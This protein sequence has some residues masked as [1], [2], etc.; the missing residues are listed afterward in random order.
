MHKLELLRGSSSLHRLI[1]ASRTELYDDMADPATCSSVPP[2]PAQSWFTAE[3]KS[4]FS[5]L[6][7][8]SGQCVSV[9]NYAD[10]A[11]ARNA[12]RSIVGTPTLSETDAQAIRTAFVSLSGAN[13]ATIRTEVFESSD[14]PNYALGAITGN[15]LDFFS[16]G[17]V[18]A[19]EGFELLE[20]A[21]EGVKLCLPYEATDSEVAQCTAQLSSARG[22]LSCVRGGSVSACTD[23][24]NAGQATLTAMNGGDLYQANRDHGFTPIVAERSSDG[25]AN[26]IG[27]SYY[28]TAI[29]PADSDL[30]GAGGFSALEGRNACSTGYRKTAGEFP[31]SGRRRCTTVMSPWWVGCVV[32]PGE[33]TQQPR[34]CPMRCGTDRAS[35]EWAP[36]NESFDRQ[37]CQ[38]TRRL[39]HADRVHGRQRHH[40]CGEPRQEGQRRRRVVCVFLRRR[41]RP[42]RD[43][44]GP[45]LRERG[46][47]GRD[48]ELRPPL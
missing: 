44:R 33:C 4:D 10:C 26:Q 23:M 1:L 9:E 40:A 17:A 19:Y 15:F 2:P 21:D 34:V 37:R 46:G 38:W 42:P 31:R 35:V 36:I 48:D 43:W 25:F 39:V 47:G 7:P 41:V 20:A 30:C 14:S 22:Y 3:E 32:T 5:I 8:R 11:I 28:A 16:E 6:C 12:A 18:A 24:I 13:L 27:L 29:V 45:C